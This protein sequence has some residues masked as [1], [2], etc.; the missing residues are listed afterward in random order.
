MNWQALWNDGAVIS[1]HALVALVAMG[2]GAFQ[3]AAPKGTTPHKALGYFWVGAMAIVAVTSF[4]IHEFRW[5]GPFSILHVLSILV[6]A[7]L[8][9]SIRAIR[10][11][12]VT[13]HR[14]SMIQ[15]YA[16]ALLLTGAFTFIP[17][18]TMHAVFFGG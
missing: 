7:T 17:G 10:Q 5:F 12:R 9:Y 11:G 18:R 3:L 15:L 8:V 6:L 2:A 16:L 14:N 13:A 1:I 4:W